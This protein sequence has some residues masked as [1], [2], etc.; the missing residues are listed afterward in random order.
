MKRVMHAY[1]SYRIDDRPSF[2]PVHEWIKRP[3]LDLNIPQK[4]P[5][6]M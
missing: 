4:L 1:L 6:E 2:G 3:E 5:R